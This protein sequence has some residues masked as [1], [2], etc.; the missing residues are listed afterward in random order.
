MPES[1][2]IEAKPVKEVK[3]GKEDDKNELV[4]N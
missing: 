2:K 4:R 3:N 1:T